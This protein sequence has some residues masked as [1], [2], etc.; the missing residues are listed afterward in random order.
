MI[1]RTVERVTVGSCQ[2]GQV[3]GEPMRMV[4]AKFLGGL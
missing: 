3:I 2:F 1:K 4:A